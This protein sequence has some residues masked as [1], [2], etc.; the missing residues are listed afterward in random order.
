MKS[1]RDIHS[2]G[3]K[4]HALVITIYFYNIYY[5]NTDINSKKLV[6]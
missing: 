3:S 6:K 4:K 5:L 1:M 2:I